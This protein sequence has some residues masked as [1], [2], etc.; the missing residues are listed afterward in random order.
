M[1]GGEEG[2]SAKDLAWL[3]MPSDREFEQ[4]GTRGV[5]VGN[6]FPWDPNRHAERM[7]ERYGFEFAAGPFERTYRR[8]S[9][10]DDMH[11]N[12]VHDYLKFVKFGYG[13]ATDHASKD[14]RTGYLSRERGAELV[15]QLDHVKPR[16]DLARWLD[17]VGMSEEEFDR[18]A[19]TFRDPRVWWIRDGLWWKQTLDG[20]PAAFGEV[21]LEPSLR[22]RYRE[23]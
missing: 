16:R 13:R 15:R 20:E 6:F 5:Y 17:Y 4:S 12:G 7:R 1:L 10:L 21:H 2:L 22:E 3:T 23:R 14:I 19:D 11:E 18:T 8:M 9:N